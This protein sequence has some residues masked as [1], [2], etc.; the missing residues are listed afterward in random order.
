MLMCLIEGLSFVDLSGK[1][2]GLLGE[3]FCEV[4]LRGF[5]CPWAFVS[6][7]F[8][9]GGLPGVFLLRGGLYRGGD[10]PRTGQ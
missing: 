3:Y 4:C 5:V 2:G 8:C 9:P 1:G 6:R 10:S 7:G